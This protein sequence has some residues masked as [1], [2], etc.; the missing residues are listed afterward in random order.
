MQALELIS[1]HCHLL[2]FSI[3]FDAQVED[4]LPFRGLER[5]NPVTIDSFVRESFE[6]NASECHEFFVVEID[7]SFQENGFFPAF[8]NIPDVDEM[9]DALHCESV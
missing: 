1:T 5:H 7:T 8:V 2:G 4:M 6:D 9:S 3:V